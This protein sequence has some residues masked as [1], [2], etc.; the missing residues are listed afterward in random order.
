VNIAYLIGTALPSPK[1]STVQ[2][3]H[4]CA[5]LAGLGHAVTLFSPRPPASELPAPSAVFAHY[6]V[7]PNFQ[8][9]RLRRGA[10]RAGSALFQL[11]AALAAS[12]GGVCYARGRHTLA[13]LLA[14]GLGGRAV[15]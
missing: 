11:R 12:G 15:Y 8:L 1:A 14:A 10:G 9:R 2:V 13:P 7:A 5:A 3:M 6:G 4:M